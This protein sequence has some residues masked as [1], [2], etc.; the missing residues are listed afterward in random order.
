MDSVYL[1]TLASWASPAS[2][3]VG[4]APTLHIHASG[5]LTFLGLGEDAPDW[6]G[7]AALMAVL[8]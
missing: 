3:V 2:P 4:L 1:T 7:D 8:A 6:D 5:A